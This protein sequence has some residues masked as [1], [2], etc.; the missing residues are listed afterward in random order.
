MPYRTV[1]FWMTVIATLAGL[2]L[3]SGA[4]PDG[5]VVAQI[6]GV[7][8][9]LGG[10]SVAGVKVARRG[11]G[12]TKCILVPLMLI[13]AGGEMG[14][15]KTWADNARRAIA[16]AHLSAR[17]AMSDGMP[18]HSE[19]CE[20]IAKKCGEA[21]DRTCKK[22]GE[23]HQTGDSIVI[24]FGA[25][26]TAMASALLAIAAVEVAKSDGDRKRLISE[27][28]EELGNAKKQARRV[29]DELQKAGV[30]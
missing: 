14:C 18:R 2:V 12:G 6:L 11:K 16:T 26:N 4:V 3:A 24:A 29:I 1:T 15:S 30:L 13:A 19:R 21:G 28:L 8:L 22:L 20:S 10:G 27:A 23:C 17:A 5:G 7:L 25:A 9:A